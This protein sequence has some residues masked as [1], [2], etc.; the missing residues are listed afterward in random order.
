MLIGS[1]LCFVIYLLWL[2][3]TMGNLS[4]DVFA[5]VIAQGGNIGALVGAI[6]E[7][8]DT[9][10]LSDMLNIFANMAIVSSFLG[11]SLA[12][13]DFIA[14]TLG[15]DDTPMG[16]FK[17]AVI[18]FAPSTFGGILFPHGFITAI[19]FAG[20]VVAINALIIPPLMLLKSRQKFPDSEYK[21]VS[22]NVIVY[23]VMF[24]GVVYA[25]CHV[26]SMLGLLPVYR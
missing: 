14:D 3:S 2:I 11:V 7:V 5:G 10:R 16:R 17:T 13:F 26:L 12:L 23:F 6:N 9:S 21:L 20:L 4:Q 15:F 24:C 22:G 19:G 1:T 18:A 25:L 8:V